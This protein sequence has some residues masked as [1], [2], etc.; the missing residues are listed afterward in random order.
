MTLTLELTLF[1]L[2]PAHHERKFELYV[3]VL[4]EFIQWCIALDCINYARWLPVHIR[5]LVNLII[6]LPELDAAFKAGNWVVCKSQ[7]VQSGVAID[8]AHEQNN[9]QVKGSGL[10]LV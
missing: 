3:D 9:A 5:D 10:M 4:T 8:L 2:I 6:R 7:K 1:L